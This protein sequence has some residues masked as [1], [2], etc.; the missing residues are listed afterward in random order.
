[1]KKSRKIA[2]IPVLVP[3]VKGTGRGRHYGNPH[4]KMVRRQTNDQ[5]MQ[6]SL[7]FRGLIRLRLQPTIQKV[8]GQYY[9][10]HEGAVTV[11]TPTVAEAN[12]FVERL[13]KAMVDI[14]TE[15]KLT[16]RANQVV[17]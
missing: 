7:T 4:I 11:E 3:P 5:M 6:E 13:R 2:K 17:R 8:N 10:W 16:V 15:L 14:A 12:M 9:G 1:M